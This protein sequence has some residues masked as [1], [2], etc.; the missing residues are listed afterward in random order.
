MRQLQID[1]RSVL[2]AAPVLLREPHETPRDA[3]VHI[4][5]AVLDHRR[6]RAELVTQ[7]LDDRQHRLGVERELWQN[8]AP[9]NDEDLRFLERDDIGGTLASIEQRYLAGYI[10]YAQKI[11]PDIA[12]VVR[13]VLDLDGARK[14]DQHAVT[15]VAAPAD[16]FV[17]G[18]FSRATGPHQRLQCGVRQKAEECAALQESQHVVGGMP[19]LTHGS[20]QLLPIEYA[21]ARSQNSKSNSTPDRLPKKRRRRAPTRYWQRQ[22]PIR[23][24]S[25]RT[26]NQA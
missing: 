14:N 19:I 22:R 21:N 18:E 4:V 12:T 10:P 23:R 24:R 8:I 5:R 7:H 11:E 26:A 1:A 3:A 6:R 2:A 9:V 13:R 15:L 20:L 16:H 17:L 25:E